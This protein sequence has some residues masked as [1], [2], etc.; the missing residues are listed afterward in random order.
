M[1]ERTKVIARFLNGPILKGYTHNF[2]PDKPSFHISPAGPDEAGTVEIQVRDLKAVFF[3]K[4]FQG[5][6][7]HDECRHF[8]RGERV[9]GRKVK[10][11]LADGELL[12][13][14]TLAYHRNR[15]GFFLTP[16]DPAS[17][18]LRAFVA[19]TAVKALMWDAGA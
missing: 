1:P 19:N 18:N 4:D 5:Q 7:E 11:L 2:D 16:V 12:V 6:P 13:G 8:T 14:T 10:V 15:P 3:V 17:N 9:V